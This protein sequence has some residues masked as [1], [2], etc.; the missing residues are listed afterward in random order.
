MVLGLGCMQI[1]Y[2]PISRKSETTIFEIFKFIF[3]ILKF[4]TFS[5]FS[6][7]F[8]GDHLFSWR[9]CLRKPLT[10]FE[11]LFNFLRYKALNIPKHAVTSLFDVT[12]AAKPEVGGLFRPQIRN[13]DHKEPL[14]TSFHTDLRGCRVTIGWV[15]MHGMTHMYVRQDWAESSPDKSNF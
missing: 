2:I 9:V 4:F 14:Y 12:V 13:L 1:S 8:F 10:D 15:G 11:Y 6:K 3:F 7:I 5:K